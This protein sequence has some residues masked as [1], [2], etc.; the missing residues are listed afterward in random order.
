[1]DIFDFGQK[2][3]ADSFQKEGIENGR[4]QPEQLEL[5]NGLV[6]CVYTDNEDGVREGETI[7]KEIADKCQVNSTRKIG[8]RSKIIQFPMR[9][10]KSPIIKSFFQKNCNYLHVRRSLGG[11]FWLH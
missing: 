6:N 7:A 8:K 1:V 11:C 4:K 5:E 10:A 3:A 9:K 2:A